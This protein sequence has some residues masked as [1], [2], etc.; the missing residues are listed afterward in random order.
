MTEDE[1]RLKRFIDGN[2][3]TFAKTYA[4]TAPHKYVICDKLDAEGRKEYEWVAKRIAEKGVDEKFYRTTFR[5]L[6]FDGMKYW[7]HDTDQMKGGVLNRDFVTS[8]YE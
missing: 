8:K 4:K 7:L 5:Y 1:L 2:A 6:Y 3:W